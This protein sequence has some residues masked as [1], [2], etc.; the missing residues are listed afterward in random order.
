[1]SNDTREFQISTLE[2]SL[3]TIRGG[4]RDAVIAIH[5]S[6]SMVNPVVSAIPVGGS[7]QPILTGYMNGSG[8]IFIYRYLTS[9][10][11]LEFE[12]WFDA[13]RQPV[14]SLPEGA[15]QIRHFVYA[16]PPSGV[17]EKPY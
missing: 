9:E 8:K 13:W 16:A 1:M 3:A 6:L 4:L 11:G 15:W 14:R 7:P 2:P 12:N 17:W 5:R 10:T